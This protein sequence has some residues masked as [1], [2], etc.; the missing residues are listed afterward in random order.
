MRFTLKP[1]FATSLLN[2]LLTA[3]NSYFM[4][5]TTTTGKM[6]ESSLCVNPVGLAFSESFCF[7]FG[8]SKEEE[9]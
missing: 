5:I 9:R 8:K 6:E 3:Y 7:S 1:Y 4:I 2:F